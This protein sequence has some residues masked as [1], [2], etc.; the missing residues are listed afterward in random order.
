MNEPAG[1]EEVIFRIADGI[2]WVILNRPEKLNALRYQMFDLL[3]AVGEQIAADPSIHAVIL[4]GEGRAFCSGLDTA[5]FAVAAKDLPP[6]EQRT[7]GIANFVQRA[8]TV[9]RDVPV[10][11]IA[12][13]SG[14]AIGAGLNIALAADLRI[15]HPETKLAIAEINWGFIPAMAGSLLLPRLVRDD[16]LRDLVYTGRT[17]S[18]AEGLALGLVTRLADDPRAAALAFAQ[19]LVTKNGDAIRAAKAMFRRASPL[20]EA[21]VLAMES[22]LQ[23]EVIGAMANKE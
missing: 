16:V 22:Q 13:L 9:W 10:P 7:H 17:V 15:A 23:A 6:I 3:I 1:T 5:S 11:V 4:T 21:A 20:D 19:E 12:A 8:V 18:A 14:A 2:A